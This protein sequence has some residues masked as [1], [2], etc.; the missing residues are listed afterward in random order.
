MS[1]ISIRFYKDHQVWVVWDEEKVQ[2]GYSC[3]RNRFH[4]SD[5]SEHISDESE[6]N[7][8]DSIL[9]GYVLGYAHLLLIR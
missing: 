4:N 6:L 2:N 3:N 5:N 1:K 9:I 8:D 7:S